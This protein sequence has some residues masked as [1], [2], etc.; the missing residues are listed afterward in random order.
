[1]EPPSAGK[2]HVELEPPLGLFIFTEGERKNK[3]EQPYG[4]QLSRKDHWHEYP[5]VIKCGIY[6][7][8]SVP[9]LNISF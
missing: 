1:M 9:L 6:A 4:P 2:W 7:S 5:K 3:K 8:L